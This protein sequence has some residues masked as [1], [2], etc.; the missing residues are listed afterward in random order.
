MGGIGGVVRLGLANAEDFGGAVGVRGGEVV[1]V[2]DAE[3]WPLGHR[4]GSSHGEPYG[5]IGG[6]V[7]ACASD[8]V[9]WN[10][11]AVNQVGD[12]AS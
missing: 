1:R 2:A 8:D 6:E 10:Y 7:S 5:G 4:G 12:G 9:E 11:P 3:P